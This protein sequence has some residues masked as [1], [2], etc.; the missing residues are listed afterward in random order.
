MLISH[1]WYR[2]GQCN[3][4]ADTHGR[5]LSGHWHGTNIIAVAYSVIT[6]MAE[7]GIQN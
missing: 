7:H 2:S 4:T 3:G 6:P 1:D 5:I